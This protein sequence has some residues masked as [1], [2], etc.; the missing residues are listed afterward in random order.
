MR[1]LSAN[2]IAAIATEKGGEPLI[3]LE[4]EWS[5][6]DAK[7]YYCD[8]IV[9]GQIAGR[10]LEV[11]GLDEIVQVSGG[12][13]SQQINV[14][15]DD[16]NGDLKAIFDQTDIHKKSVRV[17]QWFSGLD[18]DD[19][20]LL[21]K[22]QINSPVV[23]DE[24]DRR[25]SF[26]VINRIEDVEVG[27]SAEE[28]AF[29]K[30][31]DEL[32]GQPWPLCFGTVINVPALKAVPALSGTL[33]YGVGIKDFTLPRR[34]AL[35]NAITCPQTPAG[36]TCSQTGFR[37]TRCVVAYAQDAS[38]IQA[39]C[40]EIERLTLQLAEQIAYEYKEIKIFGGEA[41]P[42]NQPIVLDINGGLFAG[43]FNGNIFTITGRRHPRNDGTDHI[44][45]EDRVTVIE[46]KCEGEGETDCEDYLPSVYGP[47]Y[48]G[49]CTSRKSWEAY[50]DDE[51]AG[52]FWAQ[53]GANVRQALNAEITYIANILPSTIL[54]VAAYRT[55]NGIRLLMTVPSEFYEIRQTDYVG[56]D[57]MEIVFSRPLS[58]E[59]VENGG[60]W[61][62][63]VFVTLTSSVGPNTV[64]IIR[65]FIET[66]TDYAIDE[67]SFNETEALVENYPMH[68][69]LLSRKNLITVL[70]EIATR[71]RCALW[72]KDDTFFIRYLSKTPETVGTIVEADILPKT[73]QVELTPTE[74]LT[75]KY[76]ANW[77]KDYAIQKPNTLILRHNVK[78]YGT[79]EKKFDYYT[80]NIL[81]LVRK[82]ATFWLIRLAKTWKRLKFS[83]PL[84]KL[85]FEAFD[86]IEFT[87]N[88]VADVPFIGIVE[89]AVYNSDDNRIDFE[90][91]T[92][93][94]AGTRTP[95]SFA[96][97]ADISEVALFPTIEERDA[98]Q[99]G[100]GTEPNF[101]TIAPP[102]H[103][104]RIDPPAT[105]GFGFTLKCNGDPIPA[106]SIGDPGSPDECRQDH[107]DK[108]PSDIDDEKP[109]PEASED[110]S[111][112]INTGSSPI[113]DDG[114]G[115]DSKWQQLK[116]DQKRANNEA[117]KGRG[118]A[119]RGNNESGAD[120][121]KERP[122]SHLPDKNP[123]G[124]KSKEELVAECI[125]TVEF[126]LVIPST[127][128][129]QPPKTPAVT[130]DG[131]GRPAA[132]TFHGPH[133]LQFN[134]YM[135]AQEYAENLRNIWQQKWE[136]WSFEPSKQVKLLNAGPIGNDECEEPDDPAI[137]GYHNGDPS[138]PEVES[139]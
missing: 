118:E 34:L 13:Q 138:G 41:F 98:G 115:F 120:D 109:E 82:T 31:P 42:Q 77:R 71:A 100:S 63:D 65:W 81:D 108:K 114:T 5:G 6:P 116:E 137:I 3:V 129:Q 43:S 26:A 33:A 101:S 66:Y 90:V 88:D 79:Q 106:R 14:I 97:P 127:V 125:F 52:F 24:G 105:L 15:L 19:K 32:I 23:W 45:V 2:A 139:F 17:F 117:S 40:V 74:T 122:P 89:K 51:P 75:T 72:M 87:L 56:Y 67:T 16:T 7:Q 11:T 44:I 53:G 9:N 57:V 111:G 80:F 21:F 70:E 103:P 1:S 133:Q 119:S 121:P 22:G 60:G 85:N 69:P 94:L 59:N 55:V 123:D 104:L 128:L 30:I 27:F 29:L 38:C 50:R 107:G 37:G 93:I 135:A 132:S 110:D 12:G 47:L 36:L 96:F 130:S 8:K 46:S 18:W 86:A 126:S 99:A 20:F 134:S 102:N 78:L 39:K 83:T 10:I 58:L 35:A 95:Y 91:W 112:D 61:E 76:V 113:T 68:F 49:I 73:L 124:E 62:D 92:P 131:K 64:D 25:L 28:G 54:R 48:T 84:T 4:I 136:S